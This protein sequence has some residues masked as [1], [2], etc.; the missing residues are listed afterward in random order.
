MFFQTKGPYCFLFIKYKFPPAKIVAIKN[1]PEN[2]EQ[3]KLI[4]ITTTLII[5]YRFVTFGNL[6]LSPKFCLIV[7]KKRVICS[8][9]T[10]SFLFKTN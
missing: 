1:N 4:M 7:S 5:E 2:F 3:I 10:H 8:I 6:I 9:S